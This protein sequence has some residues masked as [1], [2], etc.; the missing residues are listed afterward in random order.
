MCPPPGPGEVPLLAIDLGGRPLAS[1]GDAD[2]LAPV[3][4][5][6]KTFTWDV[7]RAGLAGSYMECGWYRRPLILVLEQAAPHYE[8]KADVAVPERRRVVVA[9]HEPV[10]RYLRRVVLEP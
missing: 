7:H 6:E 9:D 1:R 5:G 8:S 2:A 10:L 3:L 4:T